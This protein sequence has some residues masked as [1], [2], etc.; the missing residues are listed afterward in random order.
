MKIQLAYLFD[1]N[2][3]AARFIAEI[4]TGA[5]FDA[6]A[7][8]YRGNRS[9]LVSYPMDDCMSFDFR[10]AELDI[11]AEKHEGSEISLD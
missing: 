5:I 7:K 6:K 4:N 8:L 10:A 9:A 11:L 2:W 3:Q 1:E